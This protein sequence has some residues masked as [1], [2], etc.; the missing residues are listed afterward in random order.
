MFGTQIVTVLN[1]GG[2]YS[3]IG[4]LTTGHTLTIQKLGVSGIS[5]PHSTLSNKKTGASG[6]QIP[7]VQWF[8]CLKYFVYKES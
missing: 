8:C 5:D 3:N 1:L 6:I 2:C 7:T 4:H